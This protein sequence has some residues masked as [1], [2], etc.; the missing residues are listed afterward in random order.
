M[1]VA[2]V[3]PENYGDIF[4]DYS[5]LSSMLKEVRLSRRAVAKLLTNRFKFRDVISKD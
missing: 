4:E 3:I 5:V 2:F 1:I